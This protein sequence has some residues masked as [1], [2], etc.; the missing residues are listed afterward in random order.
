MSLF[1]REILVRGIRL[2]IKS[3]VFSS[4][5]SVVPPITIRQ[6]SIYSS[7]PFSVLFQSGKSFSHNLELLRSSIKDKIQIRTLS[8]NPGARPQQ[9]KLITNDIIRFFT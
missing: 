6:I 4:S 5:V 3:L 8:T 1:P 9:I 7:V 2:R